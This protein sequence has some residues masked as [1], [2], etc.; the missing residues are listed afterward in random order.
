MSLEFALRLIPSWVSLLEGTREGARSVE[1]FPDLFPLALGSVYRLWAGGFLRLW[2]VILLGDLQ[3]G[4]PTPG[5]DFRDQAAPQEVN[6][7]QS[8]WGFICCCPSL[9]LL[10]EPYPRNHPSPPPQSVEKL[11]SMKLVPT[12][13]KVEYL[14]L[15]EYFWVWYLVYI[16]GQKKSFSWNTTFLSVHLCSCLQGYSSFMTFLCFQITSIFEKRMSFLE[17][18][19][20][21]EKC[22]FLVKARFSCLY[23]RLKNLGGSGG[24]QLYFW[25][26]FKNSSGYVDICHGRC[27]GRLEVCLQIMVS[28]QMTVGAFK[29]M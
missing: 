25:G 21:F 14:W 28:W 19:Y 4:S 27:S 22:C 2:A 5:S 17:K 29:V 18:I 16:W 11:S 15:R 26:S 10:P 6:C 13:Q 9:S 23:L 8:E 7:G 3:R 1:S 24:D 20:C 12:D